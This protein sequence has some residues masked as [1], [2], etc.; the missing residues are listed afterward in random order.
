M[1]SLSDQPQPLTQ[2]R[3]KK[4]PSYGIRTVELTRGQ[5]GFGFT[6]S[7]QGP[8]I[9]SS[10][11]EQ[12]M[13]MYL[14]VSL[15]HGMMATAQLVLL[16]SANSQLHLTIQILPPFPNVTTPTIKIFL[17]SMSSVISG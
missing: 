3:P 13:L 7:G 6:L 2:R 15:E 14:V 9:L 17:H 12:S 10:I 16:M 4:R 8:C 11:V 5:L 1:A